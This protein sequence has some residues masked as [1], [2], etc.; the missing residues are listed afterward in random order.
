MRILGVF[1]GSKKIPRGTFIGVY[2]GEL[3]VDE[4]A[5]MRGE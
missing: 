3:L 4:V 1:A 2:A 5:E